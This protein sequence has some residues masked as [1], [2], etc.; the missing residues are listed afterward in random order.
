MV[1]IFIIY[2]RKFLFVMQNNFHYQ[3]HDEYNCY[4]LRVNVIVFE[5]VRGD[6]NARSDCIHYR[7]LLSQ[8][9]LCIHAKLIC[10][11]SFLLFQVSTFST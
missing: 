8:S 2:I 7:H 5:L 1:F 9:D 11:L 10:S 3:V 6:I 4:F